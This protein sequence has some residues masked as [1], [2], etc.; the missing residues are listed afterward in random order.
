MGFGRLGAGP[1]LSLSPRS[2]PDPVERCTL[3]RGTFVATGDL[4]RGARNGAC[5]QFAPALYKIISG[6]GEKSKGGKVRWARAIA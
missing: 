4:C 3:A 5:D 1:T 6:K 2:L